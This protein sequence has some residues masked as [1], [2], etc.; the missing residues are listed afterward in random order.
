MTVSDLLAHLE[1]LGVKLVAEGDGL[2]ARAAPGILNEELRL[3]ISANK[4]KLLE[5]LTSRVNSRTPPER[6]S[7]EAILPLSSFQERLWIIQTLEPENTAFL[8]TAIWWAP[9]NSNVSAIVDAIEHLLSRHEILR[10]VFPEVDGTPFVKIVGAAE[11]ICHVL[12]GLAPAEQERCFN[13]FLNVRCKDPLIL[14]RL[15][16]VSMCSLSIKVGWE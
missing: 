4:S 8:L 6:V 1:G 15:P 16:L 9:T 10:S 14:K 5:L 12:G 3:E 13:E 11:V 2:R 7:R